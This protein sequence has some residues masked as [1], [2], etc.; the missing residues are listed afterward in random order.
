MASW[1]GWLPEGAQFGSGGRALNTKVIAASASVV[2]A[3]LVFA[4]NQQAQVRLER[5]QARLMRVSSQL[6]ELYG[7]LNA[8]VEVNERLW[9]ELRRSHLPGPKERT[10]EAA[11]H[12]WSKWRDTSLMPINTKMRDL[13]VDRADLLIES[14]LPSVL[15]EF[16]S[17]VAAVEVLVTE[18]GTAAN[19]DVALVKHPGSPFVTYLRDAYLS[20]RREQQR[21]LKLSAR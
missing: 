14:E 20:L 19:S 13:I 7:P 21:L 5:R 11:S 12:T 15:I 6:R 1:A 3:V 9:R 18:D 4:L 16:C 8:L 10:P 2:V 17:H